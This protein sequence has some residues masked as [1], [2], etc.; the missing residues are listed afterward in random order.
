[1]TDQAQRDPWEERVEKLRAA[2]GNRPQGWRWD[3]D[4]PEFAGIFERWEIAKGAGYEGRDVALAMFRDRAGKEWAVWCFHGILVD[5]LL[6]VNPQAGEL[7]FISYLGKQEP[8][9]RGAAYHAYRV[10]V[11]RIV[12]G[13]ASLAE[14]ARV[15]GVEAPEYPDELT[16]EEHARAVEAAA[17]AGGQLGAD[18]DIPF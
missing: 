12:A 2:A 10:A 6:K 7:V 8:Q 18:D 14:V 4:G 3:D 13:G 9:G 1:V 11:D 15:A 16:P 17:E 5:E